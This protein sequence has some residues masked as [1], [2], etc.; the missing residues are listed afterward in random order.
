M[1]YPR[2]FWGRTR[3]SDLRRVCY[4]PQATG[5]EAMDEPSGLLRKAALWVDVAFGMR[6][7]QFVAGELLLMG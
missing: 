3:P 7:K 1:A 6:R 4:A 5:C 2:T